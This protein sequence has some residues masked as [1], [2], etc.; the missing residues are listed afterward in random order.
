MKFASITII[1]HGTIRMILMILLILETFIKVKA[2]FLVSFFNLFSLF[3]R[4]A[5]RLRQRERASCFDFF[6]IKVHLKNFVM[7][8]MTHK[9]Y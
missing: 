8:H 6:S 5:M 7:M 4:L 9:G 1:K 2:N 3:S